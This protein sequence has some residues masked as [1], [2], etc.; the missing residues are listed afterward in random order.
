MKRILFTLLFVAGIINVSAQSERII[1]FHSDIKVDTSSTILVKE[2]IKIYAN[3]TIFKR[4]ITRTIPTVQ[5]DSS[6]NRV[7][8]DFKI[9]SVER[10]GSRSKYHTKKG[11]GTTTI[12]VGES[13]VFLREGE[14]DYTITYRM[15]GQI[16]FFENYDE[17][18]W[19]VNGFDWALPFGQVSSRVTL[20]DN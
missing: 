2:S 15:S 12:Y 9:L 1:S 16:R 3:G 13:D 18:Y 5:T 4:G 7:A 19:N 10:D 11:N 20:P 14:Y 6:G 8:L 17:I